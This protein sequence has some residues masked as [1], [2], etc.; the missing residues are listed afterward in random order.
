MLYIYSKKKMKYDQEFVSL[1]KLMDKYEK[2]K[3]AETPIL[4]KT[5][6]L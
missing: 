4:F 5:T 1:K 3:A 2:N 6:L